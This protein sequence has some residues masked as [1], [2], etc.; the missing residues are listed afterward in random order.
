MLALSIKT[1]Q[2]LVRGKQIVAYRIGGVNVNSSGMCDL[3]M[4]KVF[5]CENGWT[6]ENKKC[7]KKTVVDAK[8]K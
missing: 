3:R 1:I 4:K 7:T 2:K 5:N 6:L 8:K